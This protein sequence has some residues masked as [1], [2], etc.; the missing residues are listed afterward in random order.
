MLVPSGRSFKAVID[1]GIIEP[2][3]FGSERQEALQEADQKSEE[4]PEE[5][6]AMRQDLLAARAEQQFK[7]S[8]GK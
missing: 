8:P 1:F 7:K 6:A 3:D 5:L 2:G 4:V